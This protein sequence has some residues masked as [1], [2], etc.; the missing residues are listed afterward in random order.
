M[1]ESNRLHFRKW[2]LEDAENAFQ[3]YGDPRVAEWLSG[4]AEPTLES[5]R[6]SL[7]RILERYSE[8]YQQGIGSFAAIEKSSHDL[9]GAG[10]IKPISYSESQDS[11][12]EPEIEIGWH[13]RADKWGVGLGTEIG[14]ACLRHA[15]DTVGL[16]RVIAVAFPANVRSLKVME[17]IGMRRLELTDRYYGKSLECWEAEKM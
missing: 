3:T 7:V 10:L 8:S 13:L 16:S 6:D 17:K 12:R 1:F 9:I 14:R 4:T 5:M 11:R 2:E 15:F